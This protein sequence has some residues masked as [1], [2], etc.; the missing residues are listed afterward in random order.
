VPGSAPCLVASL[1]EP[2]LR[3]LPGLED[4][5]ATAGA[6]DTGDRVGVRGDILMVLRSDSTIVDVS[7][8]HPPSASTLSAAVTAVGAAE[9]SRYKV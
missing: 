3:Q 2:L 8:A 5:V 1:L 4:G 7:V 6:G 9:A